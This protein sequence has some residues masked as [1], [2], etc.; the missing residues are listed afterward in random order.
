MSG[1]YHTLLNKLFSAFSASASFSPCSI[2]TALRFIYL[3][4]GAIPSS[5]SYTLIPVFLQLP[6]L[7]LDST[8]GRS[9]F[10][11]TL[12]LPLSLSPLYL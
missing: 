8:Q 12:L 3:V 2:T 9:I 4:F 7:A 11:L 6:L 5:Y 1:Y 10:I